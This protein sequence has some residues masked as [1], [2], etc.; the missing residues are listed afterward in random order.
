VNNQNLAR[1]NPDFQDDG[2]TSLVMPTIMTGTTSTPE[3]EFLV[4][5][6]ELEETNGNLEILLEQS[7]KKLT[8]VVATNAKF[9]RIIA[10]DLRSPFS[11]IMGILEILKESL[12]D[13]NIDEIENYINIASESA[14]RTLNLLDNL[15]VWTVLQNKEKSFNPVKVNLYE[16]IELELENFSNSA[17]QKGISSKNSIGMSLDVS[18]DVQMIKTVLRNLINNAIKYTNNNGKIKVSAIKRGQF[19]EVSIQDT[20]IGIPQKMQEELF[21]KQEFHSTEGTN[22]E[23][24]T[25]LGLLLCMEFIELHGGQ[26]RF[27]SEPGKGSTFFFTLPK[28]K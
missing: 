28:Y 11:S 5:L 13:Y 21:N 27:I 10:H 20:G 17:R 3:N 16:L 26:I 24:G 18:A 6:R 9:I 8:E 23:Q 12:H 1:N 19:I 15:V 7:S 14:N 4:R 25:G 2:S 22:H